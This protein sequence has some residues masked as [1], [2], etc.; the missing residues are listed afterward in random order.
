M[1]AKYTSLAAAAV[2]ALGTVGTGMTAHAFESEE[3]AQAQQPICQK[4]F[5]FDDKVSNCVA[6]SSVV[7]CDNGFAYDSNKKSCVKTTALNDQDLYHQGRMLAL[8]GHYGSAVDTLGA[9]T[10][11]DSKVLTMLGYAMRKQGA[12][13][14]GIAIYHQALALDPANVN[15]H[16][17]LG[18]GYLVQGR[19]DLAE[20]EL[21]TLQGLCGTTCIQYQALKSAMYDGVWN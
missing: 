21:G 18:E 8:A 14:E 10:A 16:E 11:K 1:S 17:Y 12:V 5:I 7:K 4:G 20:V 6:E 19:I 9:V 2:L 15:T 3:P 13:A